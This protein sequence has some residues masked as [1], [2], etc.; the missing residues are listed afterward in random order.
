MAVAM[1]AYWLADSTEYP[2]GMGIL[3]AEGYAEAGLFAAGLILL[4]VALASLG[5]HRHIRQHSATTTGTYQGLGTMLKQIGETFS[6]GSFRALAI[7]GIFNAAGA[8]TAT[9]LWAYMQPYFWGFDSEQISWMLT[10][11]LLSAILAFTLVPLL[12]RGR[13]KKTVLIL[14]SWLLIL[15][16]AGPI[17]LRLTGVFP[18]NGTSELFYIMLVLGV[19]QV[20]MIAGS[21]IIVG[22]MLSD[23]VETRELA[24][25][26]RE[27][28]TLLAVQSFINK[29]A[30]GV[31]TFFGGIILAIIDFP[32]QTL[33]MAVAPEV[34]TRLGL[35]YGPVLALLYIAAILALKHFRITRDSHAETLKALAQ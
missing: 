19:L 18:E 14:L 7:S 6:N 27:E 23:I 25:G 9:A 32:D 34:I 1:Y 29:G 11:Q 16:S 24:S 13:E 28:G 4:L 15:V 8:G 35:A 10:S 30:T 3:R 21:S 33:G 12:A 22:S 2:N 17:V 31:G 26:R 5:T 20:A